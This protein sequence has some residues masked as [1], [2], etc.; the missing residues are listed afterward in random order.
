MKLYNCTLEFLL[1]IYFFNEIAEVYLSFCIKCTVVQFHFL[2]LEKKKI[3]SV[4]CL[5]NFSV[6]EINELLTLLCQCFMRYKQSSL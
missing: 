5:F 6:W 2:H 3:P 4:L 1:Y